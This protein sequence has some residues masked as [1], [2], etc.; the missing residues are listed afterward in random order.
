MTSNYFTLAALIREIGP[1]LRGA[2]FLEAYSHRPNELRVRLDRGTL[3]VLLRPIEGAL[4]LSGQEER[5]PSK[6]IH[7][8]FEML[9]GRTIED[10]QLA[11]TDRL[12]SI[13][14]PPYRLELGFFSSPN[15][16]LKEG[17]SILETFKKVKVSE[18][19]PIPVSSSFGTLGNRYKKEVEV[20]ASEAST[21][22]EETMQS[23]INRLRAADHAFICRGKDQALL[24]LI[25]L[26][27]LG[28][29]WVCEEFNSINEAIRST[30]I[31]RAKLKRISSI[32]TDLLHRIDAQIE[33]L[34]RIRSDLRK[35]AE[36]SNR[37][38]HHAA[39]GNAILMHAHEI[40]PNTE[41]VLLE[42]EDSQEV[43]KLQ[44]ELNP[45]ENA[46][47][48]FERSKRSKEARKDLKTRS[49]ELTLELAT[50]TALR[51]QVAKE[52][53]LDRLIEIQISISKGPH[54]LAK[55][56]DRAPTFREYRVAGNMIV[57]VGKNAKQNDE[58][59]LHVAKKEDIWLH[60]RGVPGSHVVL[61]CGKRSQVPKEAIEQA[62]EIA[63]YYS[64]ARTQGIAPVA[65]TQKKY[66]RKPKGAAPGA[67]VLEREEVVMVKPQI[68]GVQT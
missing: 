33:R 64:D 61:Q 37:S 10:I 66:V 39:I 44:R 43:V 47:R 24:T 23:Y 21:S 65:Y 20:I 6:N 67:V 8:F 29:E 60:A 42:I 7:A 55:Q 38:E 28:P 17:D 45:Y 13:S 46:A 59:T 57:L 40:L 35:G 68:R 5:R 41:E 4:F 48:Y 49:E 31:E 54:A 25:P 26:T 3:V 36:H 16:F 9:E 52:T 12:V 11:P 32:R 14:I 30:V 63:A 1:R 56:E 18:T 2:R 34:I 51:D 19:S 22:K 27:T 50:F 58:L 15:A 62:A 53:D